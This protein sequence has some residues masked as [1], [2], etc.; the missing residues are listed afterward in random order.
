MAQ[1]L[2]REEYSLQFA[3]FSDVWR[4]MAKAAYQEDHERATLDQFG[5]GDRPVPAE[6]PWWSADLDRV[7]AWKQDGR[8]IER[9][10]LTDP[11]DTDYLRWLR[12][13]LPFHVQAGER[14][15]S[16]S[17]TLAKQS[18]IPQYDYLI[19]DH[20]RLVLPLYDKT[21]V[22]AEAVLIDHADAPDVVDQHIAWRDLAVR[23]ATAV[24]PATA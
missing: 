12:Y 4:L 20:E 6:V 22:L 7:R 5:C 14:I 8:E 17:R 15:S 9:V 3:E 11:A 18:G 1:A 24:A 2:S 23:C 16:I 21:G 10:W 13:A 19:F